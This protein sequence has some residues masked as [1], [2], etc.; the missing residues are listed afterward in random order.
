MRAWLDT[1]EM[2]VRAVIE[3]HERDRWPHLRSVLSGFSTLYGV[4]V[5][6]RSRW[7]AGR[8][9]RMHTLP[10]RVISVGNLA[11]GG[12]GKTPVTIYLA[13]LIRR[14]GA[15]VAILSRGYGGGAEKSGGVV[16]DG[17]RILLNAAEAGDEPYLMARLLPDVPVLVGSDRYRSGMTAIQRFGV[18]VVIL[19]D[20][21]QH[22]RLARDLDIVL[23]DASHPLGNG[24]LL[25]RGTLREPV[26][27]LA[28]A[29]LVIMTRTGGVAPHQPAELAGLLWGRPVFYTNHR[30]VIRQIVTAGTPCGIAAALGAGEG[31]HYRL[32]NKKVAAFA[33]LANPASFWHS[34]R[35]LGGEPLQTQAFGDHYNYRRSEL[36]VLAAT[37]VSHGLDCLVT[38]A[39][40]F[41]RFPPN[42]V[43]PLDLVVVDADI[44][45][46]SYA[47]NFESLIGPVIGVSMPHRT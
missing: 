35:V 4:A 2:R 1:L 41:M 16:S 5:K 26:K 11:V 27:A 19:D 20:G 18:R 7:Y 47:N 24:R 21:F 22:L 33:G 40:D 36:E 44:D 42:L 10:C 38:S 15:P 17:R 29:D 31:L 23:L 25:P 12:T 32:D 14:L 9:L 3:G 46:G 13:R 6:T 43:L 37:A 30:P 34:I 28:R 8:I 39:K 45:F